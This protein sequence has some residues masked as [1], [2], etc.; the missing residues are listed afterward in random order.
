MFAP[1][2]R[3]YREKILAPGKILLPGATLVKN[4]KLKLRMNRF[5]RRRGNTTAY[6]PSPM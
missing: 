6:S 2:G 4:I 5:F 3:P 1:I